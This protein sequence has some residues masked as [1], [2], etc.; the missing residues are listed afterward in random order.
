MADIVR[1]AP[2][3]PY[4]NAMERKRIEIQIN[5]RRTT[6]A[7]YERQL[8]DLVQIQQKRLE[9][10]IEESEKVIE[11]LKVKLE[12]YVDKDPDKAH[13]IDAE[14]SVDKNGGN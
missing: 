10:Q 9:L 4:T 1:N 12:G 6:I 13:V 2:V 8:H 5:E 7:V 14:Y 11:I 3:V